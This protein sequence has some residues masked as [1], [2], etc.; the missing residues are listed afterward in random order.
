MRAHARLLLLN[1]SWYQLLQMCSPP[2]LL[3]LQAP[4]IEYIYVYSYSIY[5]IHT[6]THTHTHTCIYIHIYV[7]LYVYIYIY[8]H[9]YVYIY[10]Y[11]YIYM[12]IVPTNVL[13]IYIY[14][15]IH[16]YI[17]SSYKCVPRPCYRVSKLPLLSSTARHSNCPRRL[18]RWAISRYGITVARETARG[19]KCRILRVCHKRTH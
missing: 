8:I 13:Y 11:I 1:A 3:C 5:S 14:I 9:I 12:Y 18:T 2:V 15:Y 16:M 7:Y 10:V 6:H 4:T 17:Y 19:I